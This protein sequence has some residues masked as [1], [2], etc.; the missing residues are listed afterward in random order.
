MVKLGLHFCAHDN[1]LLISLLHRGR[2]FVSEGFGEM[3]VQCLGMVRK[4]HWTGEQG[5]PTLPDLT[6][7][8]LLLYF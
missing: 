4:H 3:I 7:P 8:Q 2:M 5:T 6:G 1:L